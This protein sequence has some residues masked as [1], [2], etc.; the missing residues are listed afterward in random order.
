MRR[1]GRVW[2]E[3]RERERERE[4]ESVC[5]CMSVR[6]ANKHTVRAHQ[7]ALGSVTLDG[8]AYVRTGGE[9]RRDRECVRERERETET[10]I[11]TDNRD[12]EI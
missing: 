1:R 6:D 7:V 3:R 10:D 9:K 8:Y 11:Q 4:R 12:K 5:V 2:G